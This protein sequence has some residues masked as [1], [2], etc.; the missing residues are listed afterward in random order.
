MIRKLSLLTTAFAVTASLV[1]PLP[2]SALGPPIFLDRPDLSDNVYEFFSTSKDGLFQ[3]AAGLA[4]H[5]GTSFGSPRDNDQSRAPRLAPSIAY[6]IQ[7]AYIY[8]SRYLSTVPGPR[9]APPEDVPGFKLRAT[10]YEPDRVQRAS[11]GFRMSQSAYV[12]VSV[13]YFAG[14]SPRG[15]GDTF[16]YYGTFEGCSAGMSA[17]EGR[18]VTDDEESP[19]PINGGWKMGCD[20]TVL[21]DLGLDEAQQAAITAAFG[22]ADLKLRGKARSGFRFDPFSG[23]PR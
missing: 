1:A 22:R 17:K 7:G 19:Q 4:V 21:A 8:A 5:L 10:I 9:L 11:T 14:A 3:S 15:A 6:N 18:D 20:K 16:Y 13:G 2:A 23:P 12:F